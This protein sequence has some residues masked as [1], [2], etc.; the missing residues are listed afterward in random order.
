M[1][2]FRNTGITDMKTKTRVKTMVA[3]VV[4]KKVPDF[5][6]GEGI[7]GRFEYVFKL[8][9]DNVSS[10]MYA[11]AITNEEQKLIRDAV[12]VRWTEKKPRRATSSS[13]GGR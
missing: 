10:D 8:R 13:R 9:G 5:G 3:E 7:L 6:M 12:E 4:L 1:S 2:A 11:A